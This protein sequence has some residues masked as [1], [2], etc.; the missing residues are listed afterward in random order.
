MVMEGNNEQAGSNKPESN[1]RET[2]REK[3]WGV[4]SKGLTNP[5][6]SEEVTLK[7]R[8]KGHEAVQWSGHSCCTK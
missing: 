1:R 4:E 7:L 6:A 3:Q 2:D 5:P 8:P